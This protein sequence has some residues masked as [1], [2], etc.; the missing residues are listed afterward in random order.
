M[1]SFIRRFAVTGAVVSLSAATLA[2]CGSDDTAATA[3][4]AE[5]VGPG[6][7]RGLQAGQ[8]ADER[9]RGAGRER[10]VG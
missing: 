7:H 4:A 1:S 3:A 6:D 2:A 10:S 9:R 5:L 8:P